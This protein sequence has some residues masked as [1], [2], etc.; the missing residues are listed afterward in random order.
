M[1]DAYRAD[2]AYIHDAGFGHFARH[3]ASDLLN[4]LRA[5]N[6]NTGLVVDLGCGSGITAEVI[7]AAGYAVLGIDIS[8]SLVELAQKRVPAGQF[9]V[10]SFLDM[11]VPPCVAV[12]AIGECF[13]YAFDELNSSDA[14]LQ[15]FR[16][17][18]QAL[19]P[20]GMFLFDVAEPGRVPG[21]AALR[22]YTEGDDWAVLMTAEEHPHEQRLTR[23][24]TTFRQ[25]GEFYRRDREVHRLHL[26]ERAALLDHLQ[27]VGFHAQIIGRYGQIAFASG[28]IGFLAR[29]QLAA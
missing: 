29:K 26:L 23:W 6:I 14:Q 24:I 13:N 9:R 1:T 22:T 5:Q 2:L 11:P 17:I 12:T 4:A 7:A 19:A 25:V 27:A 20:A 10:G 21:G 15:M 3:A 18:Y 28:H 8:P 16:R